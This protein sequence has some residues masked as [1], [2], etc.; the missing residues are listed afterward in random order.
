MTTKAGDDLQVQTFSKKKNL[1]TRV[2][3]FSGQWK[4]LRKNEK[5]IYLKNLRT[6]IKYKHKKSKEKY[7]AHR[8]RR[9]DI[10]AKVTIHYWMINIRIRCVLLLS[11]RDGV[12]I[13][14]NHTVASMFWLIICEMRKSSSASLITLLAFPVH[15]SDI[16]LCV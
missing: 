12:R 1:G 3:Y 16:Y 15:R 5:N 9:H 11:P 4:I 14:T 7:R 13:K 2:F 6:W 10:L 8:R